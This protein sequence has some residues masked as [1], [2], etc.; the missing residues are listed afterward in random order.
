VQYRGSVNNNADI[1]NST[2]S[3]TA[4]TTIP[5]NQPISTN[6]NQTQNNTAYNNSRDSTIPTNQLS[7]GANQTTAPT[8]QNWL[9]KSF[10]TFATGENNI[11]MNSGPVPKK[12]DTSTD[13][14]KKSIPDADEAPNDTP[15]KND[16]FSNPAPN[17]L[18]RSPTA[19]TDHVS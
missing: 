19:W 9:S 18:A 8:I 4:A 12:E 11:Y 3:N 5:T 16:Q 10:N 17:H 14:E 15:G 6:N 2:L 1:V 13:G 7:A